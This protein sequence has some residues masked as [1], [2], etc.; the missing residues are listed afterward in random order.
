MKI[1]V[2]TRDG[3]PHCVDIKQF[4]SNRKVGY[5]E[6][7][8]GSNISRDEVISKFPDVKSLPIVTLEDDIIGS[9]ELKSLVNEQPNLFGDT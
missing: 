3:C 2:Y 1:E 9:S 6:F 4:L 8:I 7:K 5:T